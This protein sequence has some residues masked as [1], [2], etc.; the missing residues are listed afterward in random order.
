MKVP[1]VYRV[2]LEQKY[3][4]VLSDN[5]DGKINNSFIVTL[6]IGHTVKYN[7]FTGNLSITVK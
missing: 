4:E 1:I 5:I 2:I 3:S 7:E 6:I